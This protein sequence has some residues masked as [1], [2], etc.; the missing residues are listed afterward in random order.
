MKK[1]L[2]ICYTPLQIII[3]KKIIQ[4]KTDQTIKPDF[5]L[6]PLADTD[7]FR[8]YFQSISELCDE[9]VYF[10]ELQ[11]KR[12]PFYIS[13]IARRFRN[14]QYKRVYLANIDSAQI[15]FILSFMKFDEINTFDDGT[16]NITRRGIY[17]ED[18]PRFK[19]KLI[20]FMRK[21]SGNKYTSEKIKQMSSRHYTI[22]PGFKNIIDNVIPI[23]LFSNDNV[24]YAHSRKKKCIVILGTIYDHA[25]KNSKDK[26]LLISL[27]QKVIDKFED[28]TIYYLPHPVDEKN[29][30]GRVRNYP[31][32]MIAEEIILELL[33]QYEDI[34]LI[35]F[36]SST[37]FN[38]MNVKGIRNIVIKSKLLQDDRNELGV[39]LIKNHAEVIKIDD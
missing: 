13:Y 11:T 14:K 15:Q 32:K 33:Q 3:A 39:E 6:I 27:I 24:Q 38:L 30:F 8:Y 18:Q 36:A 23:E 19:S 21:I 7:R 2:Y 17:Y 10:N 9:S 26:T 35:G 22:Y 4:S 34:E 25:C 12:F 5:V 31:S 29:Y 20:R 37:Q 16:A 28:D 1:D